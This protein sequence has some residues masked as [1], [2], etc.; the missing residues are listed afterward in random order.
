[1]KVMYYRQK[2]RACGENP[3]FNEKDRCRPLF[4]RCK[5]FRGM[6]ILMALFALPTSTV[7][8]GRA[9]WRELVVVDKNLF[10]GIIFIQNY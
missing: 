4:I 7:I 5:E 3:P 9:S 1:M 10:S 8:V 6:L 2:R